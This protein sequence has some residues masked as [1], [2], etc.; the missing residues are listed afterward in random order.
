MSGAQKREAKARREGKI[1]LSV[2]N[3]KKNVAKERWLALF[4]HDGGKV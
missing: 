1:C 3:E 2:E 4:K